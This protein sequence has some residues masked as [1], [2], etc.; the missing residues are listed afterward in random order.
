VSKH[1]EYIIISYPV[2]NQSI[3]VDQ[4]A[5]T[6]LNKVREQVTQLPLSPWLQTPTNYSIQMG[7]RKQDNI[8]TY[9][10]HAPPQKN[11]LNIKPPL[12]L[13]HVSFEFRV[14]PFARLQTISNKEFYPI[15]SILLSFCGVF[16]RSIGRHGK[17]PELQ[18]PRVG[19]LR[20]DDTGTF[21]HLPAGVRGLRHV[22]GVP[23]L[24]GLTPTGKFESYPIPVSLQGGSIVS[25]K[26]MI[27]Y[28]CSLTINTPPRRRDRLIK[29]PH[30]QN[31]PCASNRF[32]GC[33]SF[34]FIWEY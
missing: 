16:G 2:F 18:N 5:Q 22:R 10:H 28:S 25:W 30:N 17:A 15:I 1:L 29:L 3:R 13:S 26:F 20:L 34:L 14:S 23:W 32:W 9:P 8:S 6:L 27:Y 19:C 31:A 21:R 12:P 7:K 24:I 33:V 11:R 4:S